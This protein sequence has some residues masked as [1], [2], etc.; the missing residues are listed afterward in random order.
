MFLGSGAVSANELTSQGAGDQ[1]IIEKNESDSLNEKQK[2][3][4]TYEAPAVNQD[5]YSK[6]TQIPENSKETQPMSSESTISPVV[7]G[8][9]VD[10][11][12]KVANQ[13]DKANLED[14]STSTDT[15]ASLRRTRR[16]LD[17][18]A[19]VKEGGVSITPPKENT[20]SDS[21]HPNG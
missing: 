1:A 4:S 6:E 2:S 13:L 9:V 11:F 7:D 16:D 12:E 17:S 10:S 18:S 21:S 14:R 5:K 3:E 15:A 8:V 20:S 19:V